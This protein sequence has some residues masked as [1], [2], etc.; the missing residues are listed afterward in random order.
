MNKIQKILISNE[1]IIYEKYLKKVILKILV[2]Y[3]LIVF[4]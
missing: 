3:S 4:I 2:S 1:F